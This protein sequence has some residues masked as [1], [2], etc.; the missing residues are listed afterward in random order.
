[1]TDLLRIHCYAITIGPDVGEDVDV[2]VGEYR[3]RYCYLG[4]EM[5]PW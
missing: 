1:M 3:A 4:V 2:V 5:A